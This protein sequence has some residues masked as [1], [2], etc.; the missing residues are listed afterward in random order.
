MSGA[1]KPTLVI[2][3]LPVEDLTAATA[4]YTKVLGREPLGEPSPTDVEF[5]LRDG[6]SLLL[7]TGDEAASKAGCKVL[8][9][10]E[11]LTAEQT[12]LT[13]LDVKSSDREEIEGALA[14]C[15]FTS[16]EGHHLGLVQA[17]S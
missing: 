13:S 11:D 15:D 14:W 10:V 16:P 6:V 8:L 17:L 9:G 5:E 12:R 7:T 2:I 1:L 3:N 4:W